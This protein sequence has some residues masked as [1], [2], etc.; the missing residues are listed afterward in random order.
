[1]LK[2]KRDPV[3]A[4]RVVSV[5]AGSPGWTRQLDS[6]LVD[7]ET[8]L[9]VCREIC[10]RAVAQGSGELV[11]IMGAA[12]VGKSRLS[13]EFLAGV[14]DGAT[15]LTGQCLPYGEGITFRPIVSADPGPLRHR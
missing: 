5:T 1:M 7:R 12:G 15:V 8:E 2:G 4:W 6:Q 10:R 3:P 11:T 13:T 9:T 14:A